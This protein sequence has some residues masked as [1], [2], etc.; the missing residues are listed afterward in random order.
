MPSLSTSNI[1]KAS[2][3]TRKLATPSVLTSDQAKLYSQAVR[4]GWRASS[5]QIWNRRRAEGQMADAVRLIEAARILW[6]SERQQEACNAYRRA[7]DLLE[8]LARCSP[9]TASAA[10]RESPPKEYT[11]IPLALLA[12]G[13]YQMA[14]LS[15]MA[16]GLLLDAALPFPPGKILAAF[17]A[18]D[19]NELLKLI[20]I[21]WKDRLDKTGEAGS[22][23]KSTGEVHIL[24]GVVGLELV[25]CLGLI[26]HGIRVDDR[27]RLDLAIRKLRSMSKY[28]ARTTSEYTWLV[29]SLTADVA[30]EYAENSIWTGLKPIRTQMLGDGKLRVDAFARSMVRSN[31]SLLWPSQKVALS[32]LVA[33]ESFAICTP[34]ASGKT[35][36][37]EI[38]LLQ[39]LYGQHA[40]ERDKEDTTQ[41]ESSS[42]EASKAGAPLAL[43]LVPSR[44]LAAEVE[45]RL[46][47]DF[48]LVDTTIKVTSLYG[49]K[50]WTLTDAWLTSRSPVILVCTVEMAESL[51]RYVGPLLLPR[52]SLIIADE[53]HQVQFDDT[54]RDQQDLRKSRNRAVR[55]EQFAARVFNRLPTCRV[56]ALSAVAGGAEKVI[57]EWISRNRDALPIG[58]D[59]RSTRQLIG[60]LECRSDGSANIIIKLINGRRLALSDR[61]DESYI[62]LPF[63]K[64]PKV[65]GPLRSDLSAFCQCHL[66][67]AAMQLA[68]AGRTV[69][70]S[71]AQRI[72]RLE[73][74]TRDIILK[75][76]TWEKVIPNFFHAPAAGTES[77]AIYNDCLAA[78]EDYCGSDSHEVFLLRRG[79]A[80]HHGQLPVRVRRLMTD[81]IQRG[82]APVAIATST[83]TEGVNM[84]FDVILVPSILRSNL[85][86]NGGYDTRLLSAAEFMNLAGRAGRPGT[87]VEG[88]TL[89]V[90]P[91]ETTSGSGTR[92]ESEQTF[93]I[94]KQRTNFEQLLSDIDSFASDTSVNEPSSPLA[95]LLELLWKSWQGIYSSGS[96]EAFLVWLE[97]A[98][99]GSIDNYLPPYAASDAKQ[100]LSETLDSLDMILLAAVTEAEEL[101]GNSLQVSELETRLRSLWT[102]TYASYAAAETQRL[103]RIFVLRGS[104][105]P[106]TIFPDRGQRR[107]LYQLNL[108][109]SH[110]KRFLALSEQLEK[111][112]L[113]ANKYAEWSETERGNFI[114][115]LALLVQNDKV[116]TFDS[117]LN[118][119]PIIWPK[120]LRW[121][122][123]IPRSDQPSATEVKDWLGVAT[124]KFE[125][126]LG[127]AIGSVI[128]A[129]WDRV[130]GGTLQIPT[131]L[132]WQTLTKLPWA[133]L[134]IREM[135]AWG[136]HDP[137]IAMLMA[138]GKTTTRL[139]AAV[140]ASE[141]PQWYA[142]TYPDSTLDDYYHPL[143]IERWCDEKFPPP[144]SVSRKTLGTFSVQLDRDFGLASGARYTVIPAVRGEQMLWFDPAGYLL[145]QCK[146]PVELL[147]EHLD[148][149]DF[150]LNPYDST[151]SS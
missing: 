39:A 119:K 36:V 58:K 123:Q 18:A 61:E 132:N 62:P 115:K 55:F 128:S 147:D 129:I 122:L 113:E 117:Y 5:L 3:L 137:I 54:F 11:P 47:A 35:T 141:Y 72:D 116:F 91:A 74:R 85:Q 19:F 79:I 109:P 99:P 48:R 98:N 56:V 103:E 145:A 86:A 82:I 84:P 80:V 53:A 90:S 135:L 97:T 8:W 114:E 65:T 124:A 138:A 149:I 87:G 136:T 51:V 139:Q 102:N 29:I 14:G 71:V 43:Y 118:T 68:A 134:W 77:E 140:A 30:N 89:V 23:H 37:A 106:V 27:K 150:V 127:T 42:L 142:A 38:A 52:I 100:E 88:I 75:A 60:S 76:K 41:E 78:C 59:Y 1:E 10:A 9:A 95:Q 28:V 83:L 45:A 126:Q 148:G 22:W 112:L 13:A 32:K 73:K 131:L 151:V 125:F 33:S 50:D 105:L 63:G 4:M 46:Y 70:I 143:W 93:A 81:V 133:A 144:T 16:R 31:R 92:A 2:S 26:G 21:F 12:A 110:G 69:L 44:A 15:A 24:D 120:I 66:L 101:Q 94:R 67:W 25:R 96:I 6:G 146:R 34:T 64:M 108:P 40:V 121:W 107:L 57:A 17:L 7:G 111:Q 104:V 130:N 49:G 20:A